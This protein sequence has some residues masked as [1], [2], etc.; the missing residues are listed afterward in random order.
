MCLLAENYTSYNNNIY[1]V[2]V[3]HYMKHAM[4]TLNMYNPGLGSC[5]PA[6]CKPQEKMKITFYNLKKAAGS[7]N[8]TRI[9]QS[10]L[11]NSKQLDGL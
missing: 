5:A 9:C 3:V 8:K 2:V 11:K 6:A 10:P 7:L 4:Q 1:Q